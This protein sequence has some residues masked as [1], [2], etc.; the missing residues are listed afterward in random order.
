MALSLSLRGEMSL[1]Y[2][3][4]FVSTISRSVS[5]TTDGTVSIIRLLNTG[6]HETVC[7]APVYSLANSI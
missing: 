2:S 7:S 1:A 5:S 3:I 4:F 6:N